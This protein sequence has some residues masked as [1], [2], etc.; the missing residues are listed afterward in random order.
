VTPHDPTRRPPTRG[1]GPGAR[2]PG[3]PRSR[4]VTPP[5][6]AERPRDP[7][8]RPGPPPGGPGARGPVRSAE[9]IP[10]RPPPRPVYVRPPR[11]RRLIPRGNPAR[12]LGVTLLAIA[13]VLTLFAARLVQLQ[14]LEAGRYR[15]LALL[16]REKPIALPA[17]RGRTRTRLRGPPG[18][19]HRRVAGGAGGEGAGPGV[20]PVPAAR[21]HRRPGRGPGRAGWQRLARR[22]GRPGQVGQHDVDGPLGQQHR[23]RVHDVLAG[24][25]AMHGA[26]RGLGHLPRQRAGQPGHGVPG[27]RGEFAEFVRIEVACLSRRGDCLARAR[28]RQPGPLE[29]PGQPGLGVQHRL[30]PRDVAGLDAAPGENPAEQASRV[31][32]LMVRHVRDPSSPVSGSPP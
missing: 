11:P 23:G 8:R 15:V 6:G 18:G 19:R 30:Q 26:D 2:P 29:R 31:R 5:A 28:G 13:F 16:Q 21:C 24:G 32:L 27:Q 7:R 12:R 10:P 1:P 17:V 22:L 4:R 3:T 25:P 20:Q 14:G 9:K